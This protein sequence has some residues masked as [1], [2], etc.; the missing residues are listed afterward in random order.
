[1][2]F[3][4]HIYTCTEKKFKDISSRVIGFQFTKKRI[5]FLSWLVLFEIEVQF[6]SVLDL[7]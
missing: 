7:N 1:M 3:T 2:L 6:S 5:F 4:F